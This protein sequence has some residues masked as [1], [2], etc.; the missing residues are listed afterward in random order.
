MTTAS[1]SAVLELSGRTATGIEVPADVLTALGGSR[2]PA[3]SVTIGAHRWSTTLGSMGGRTMIPVSAENRTAAGITAGETLQ[4][5]LEL[6]T[7]PPPLALPDDLA[8]ALDA[9]PGLRA[10]FDRLAPSRRK[11]HVRSV[12][13][14]KKPETRQRRVTAVVDQVRDASS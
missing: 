10:A 1:F 11:E 2:R 7:A 5:R 14:A 3:V 6:E 4:V 9:G 13:D 12:V 8:A